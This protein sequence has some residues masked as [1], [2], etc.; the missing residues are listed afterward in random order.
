M[1]GSHV[2][3]DVD[4]DAG[5]RYRHGYRHKWR[6]RY[7][8]WH[9]GCYDYGGMLKQHPREATNTWTFKVLSVVVRGFIRMLQDPLVLVG[10][11]ESTYPANSPYGDRTERTSAV[12]ARHCFPH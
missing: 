9:N 10:L 7:R 6:Y 2:G 11:H 4:V 1:I 5:Y 12:V 3:T 8:D